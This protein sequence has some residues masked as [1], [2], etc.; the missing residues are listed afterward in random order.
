MSAD[1]P[2]PRQTPASK[3]F[4]AVDCPLCKHT[5]LWAGATRCPG[6]LGGKKISQFKRASLFMQYPELARFDTDPAP[7]TL[8][9]DPDSEKP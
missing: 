7:F 3:Q 5:E 6:C 8:D 2:T 4:A 9:V 1:A